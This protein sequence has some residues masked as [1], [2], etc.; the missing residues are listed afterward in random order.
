MIFISEY[1]ERLFI[2]L[3]ISPIL[4]QSRLE[5]RTVL[6]P[7]GAFCVYGLQ[8]FIF[9]KRFTEL[10]YCS[11]VDSVGRGRYNTVLSSEVYKRRFHKFALYFFTA[12]FCYVAGAP[13]VFTE[14]EMFG[15]DGTFT[16][17]EIIE[18]FAENFQPPFVVEYP[19][20]LDIYFSVI[21]MMDIPDEK[22]IQAMIDEVKKNPQKYR[23]VA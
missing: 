21:G 11:T 4:I 9:F 22:E 7:G 3:F 12:F 18:R 16:V 15:N 8:P 23:Y 10:V 5:S 6:A 17:F 1:L 2:T 20:R 14:A 13:A 19:G